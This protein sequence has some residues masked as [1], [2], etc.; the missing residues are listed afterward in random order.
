MGKF[1]YGILLVLSTCSPAFAQTNRVVDGGVFPNALVEKNYILNFGAEKNATFNVSQSS[2]ITTRNTTSPLF[3]NADFAIDATA[4]GQTVKWL[5]ANKDAGLT[6][7]CSGGFW[8]NG[9]ASLYKASIE[10]ASAAKLSQ[11]VTLSSVSQSTLVEIFF[12]CTSNARVVIE[13]TSASAAAINVDN[14]YLGKALR[15]IT[16]DI[17]TAAVAYTPTITTGT[18]S[19]TNATTRGWYKRQGDM[20]KVWGTTVFTAAS[21]AF[22]QVFVG[23][24]S[25][26]SIDT[27]K[28]EANAALR[29]HLGNGHSYNAGIALM[30]LHVIYSTP[31]RVSLRTFKAIAAPGS[32]ET[33]D[34]SST[35]PITFDNNDTISWEFEVPIAQYSPATVISP[36]SQGWFVAAEIAG[37]NASL[38]TSAVTSYTEITNGSLTM[39]PRTGSAPAGVMCSSTNTAATPTTSASTCSAGNESVGVSFNIPEPGYYKACYYGAG[40]S[41]VNNGTAA[42]AFQLI[43]TPINAQ[44][45]TQEG[46]SRVMG[47]SSD[48]GVSEQNFSATTCGTFYFSSV[49]QKGIRLMY[50]VFVAG[51]VTTNVL[52][53]DAS[54]SV[55]QRNGLFTV[56]KIAPGIQNPYLVGS[57]QTDA[58]GVFKQYGAT[59]TCSATSSIDAQSATWLSSVGNIS[60]GACAVTFSGTPFSSSSYYCSM[61][62]HGSTTASFSFPKISSKTTS[63]FT[64]TGVTQNGA[65]TGAATDATYD[66]I[67]FG[68]K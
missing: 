13:S 7:N 44:T 9:D 22:N 56:E 24:P 23:L 32:I 38:G 15:A 29:Q 58:S 6:G 37:A 4:S 60:S 5:S 61:L 19:M 27:A 2:S 59:I 3:D 35:N 68:P 49:G 10:T 43:E 65:T 42:N 64:L 12:P 21:A 54:A 30:P 34:I 62:S 66:L 63:G 39:T 11:E 53:L 14:V 16:A 8:Y 57:I 17:D 47:S 52:A 33:D 51:T 40:Y 25:G 36:Q 45:L 1:L 48:A 46:G 50:E 31:V 67:C 28:L 18:G 26:F 20:M 41:A 55:G